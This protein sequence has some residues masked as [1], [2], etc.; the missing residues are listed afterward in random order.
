M[1]PADV[2]SLRR[3]E[4]AEQ[5]LSDAD[6]RWLRVREA[7]DKSGVVGPPKSGRVRWLPLDDVAMAVLEEQRGRAMLAAL[8][9][10]EGIRSCGRR[11]TA[12][13]PAGTSTPTRWATGSPT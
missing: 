1:A 13:G 12:G 11:G 4:L 9:V 5:R 7:Y 10:G 2:R 3:G 6:G 8:A